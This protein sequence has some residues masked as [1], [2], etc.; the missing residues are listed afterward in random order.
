MQHPDDF[1]EKSDDTQP[2]DLDDLFPAADIYQ[3]NGY[4]DRNDYLHSLAEDYGITL[5]EVQTISGLLGPTEDFDAL[6]TELE[7]YTLEG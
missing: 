4:V 2:L 6:I 3:E 7:L 1:F 5:T